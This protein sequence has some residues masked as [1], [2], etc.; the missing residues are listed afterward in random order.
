M[1]PAMRVAAPTIDCARAL[2]S[3]TGASA[4]ASRSSAQPRIAARGARKSWA[5]TLT[6]S[7]FVRS[8]STRRAFVSSSVS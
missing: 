1:S 2:R 6:I 5:T 4:W 7:L 8:S 3:S